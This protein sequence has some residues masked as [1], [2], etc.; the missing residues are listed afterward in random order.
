M[1]KI[2]LILYY[3]KNIFCE[4]FIKKMVNSFLEKCL[5]STAHE[6]I[7]SSNMYVKHRKYVQEKL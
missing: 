3:N 5:K 4:T 6:F 2:A 1:K 7:F